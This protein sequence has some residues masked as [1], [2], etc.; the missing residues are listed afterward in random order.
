MSALQPV[1]STAARVA[2]QLRADGPWEVFAQRTR[3]YELHLNGTTI[4]LARGP[5]TV[6]GYGLRLLRPRGE[7]TGRGFQ[8]STDLTADGIRATVATAEAVARLSSFPAKGVELPKPGG[9]PASPLIR[10]DD[11]WS[12]PMGTLERFVHALTAPF[13]GR[14][15]EVLSFGS[16]RASLNENSLAN[17]N[18]LRFA[19]PST[20]VEYEAAVKASGGP[21]GPP[22][23]EYWVNGSSRRATTDHLADEVSAWCRY[24][25]DVRRAV[26]PPTGD[27]PVILPPGVLTTILPNVLSVRFTGTARLREIAPALGTSIA[28][29]SLTVED[30]GT[31][32]WATG[33]GPVDDEGTPRRKQPLI[34]GGSVAGL[35]YDS[36]HGAAFGVP[37]TGSAARAAG[38]GMR[39]PRRFAHAPG[40]SSTT[41]SIPA[42][43]GGSDAELVEAAG[44]GIWV[45]QLGWAFP[46]PFSGAFG[47][48]IRIGYRIRGGKLA[49]PVRGGT[50]GGVV[51]APP[52]APSL[53]AN[54]VAIGSTPELTDQMATPPLLVR[55]LVVAGA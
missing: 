37:S 2:D 49:E 54:V 29:S 10:D 4:E 44:D 39:D 35:L 47:G 34:S 5:I 31:Y 42:G 8:A 1:D 9:A 21:E 40:L 52:G 22:P 24:A 33:S 28:A 6:E 11:L 19:Y 38:F 30:D 13:D 45:Q 36:L 17:S 48:E 23:G 25:Q 26:Q 20:E 16:V 27:L 15:N 14:S 43:T 12:D 46:D 41:L 51:M 18:G 55:P 7:Q 50:V 3:R 53:L 32:P